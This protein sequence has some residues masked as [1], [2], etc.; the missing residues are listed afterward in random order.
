MLRACYQRVTLPGTQTTP[1][2]AVYVAYDAILAAEDLDP[3]SGAPNTLLHLA[4]GL[5]FAVTETS[6]ELF[7][8]VD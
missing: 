5:T 7:E 8:R 4:G 1:E 3:H 6:A 2:R